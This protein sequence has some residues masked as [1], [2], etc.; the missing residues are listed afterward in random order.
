MVSQDNKTILDYH[1]RLPAKT[2][3]ALSTY[4]KWSRGFVS[5]RVESRGGGGLLAVPI[6]WGEEV[7]LGRYVC[8]ESRD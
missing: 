6:G 5:E 4:V 8:G 7:E 2:P 3:T 1:R